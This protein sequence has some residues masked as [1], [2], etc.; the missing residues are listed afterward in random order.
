LT[1]NNA[2][3]I[4]NA[5]YDSC[6]SIWQT[7]HIDISGYSIEEAIQDI[8]ITRENL[9][10]EKINILAF[11]YGTMLSQL[12]FK[13]YPDKVNKMVLI[14]ARP[15]NN[16]LLSGTTVKN[17]V[18]KVQTNFNQHQFKHNS[19]INTISVVSNTINKICKHHTYFNRYRLFFMSLSKLYSIDEMEK[20]INIYIRAASG[21]V[22][23]LKNMYDDFYNNFPKNITTGDVILKKQNRVNFKQ[24]SNNKT[25]VDSIANTINY[26]YS[27]KIKKLEVKDTLLSEVCNIT[28][29][30]M[31]ISDEFD[32]AAPPE[33]LQKNI[34]FKNY[35]TTTVI[36]KNAGHLDLFYSKLPDVK[37]KTIQYLNK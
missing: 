16:F 15:L 32:I 23:E 1:F 31:F 2:E 5:A 30:V 10:Y 6:L 36:I 22:E 37:Q 33:L 11:S 8:E 34:C 3:K 29:D 25:F 26:W 13:T 17:F 18:E 20:N 28:V 4:F 9:N 7:K 27:P 12:Y 19:T 24:Q 35:N 21:S 14:G